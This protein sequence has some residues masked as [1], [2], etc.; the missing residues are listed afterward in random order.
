ML[1]RLRGPRDERGVVAIMVAILTCFLVIPMAALAV[2]IGVQRVTRTDAQSVADMVALDL[3]REID[4]R[5]VAELNSATPSL[6][7]LA[8]KSAQRGAVTGN[9]YNVTFELGTVTAANFDPNDPDS[10]AYFAPMTSGK[11]NSVRVTVHA[12]VGFTFIGG[13]GGA[14]RSAIG[15]GAIVKDPTDEDQ[16][17][18]VPG[19]PDCPYVSN[20]AGCMIMDSY[21]AAI[22]SGDSAVLGPL[23]RHL[24]T[25]VDA[26]VLSSSGL[27]DANVNIVKFLEILKADLNVGG[28]EEVLNANVSALQVVTAA[29]EALS[30]DAATSVAAST[31]MTQIGAHISGGTQILVSDLL[32]V[33]QGGTSALGADLNALDLAAAAVQIANGTS[34]LSLTVSGADLIG[35]NASAI[36]GS[37]PKPVCLGQGR[38]ESAQTRV[39]A[40]ATVDQAGTVAGAVVDLTNSVTGSLSSLLCSALGSLLNA[41]CYTAPVISDIQV[42][43][44]VELARAAGT[45]TDV[46]CEGDQTYLSVLKDSSLVPATVTVSV[47]FTLQ[48]KVYTTLFAPPTVTNLQSVVYATLSTDPATPQSESDK[49]YVPDDYDNPQ[50]GPSPDLSVSNL[51]VVMGTSGDPYLFD[52]VAGLANT[53]QTLLIAPL[54]NLVVKPLLTG[55]STA[56]EDL[57][58]LSLAGSTYTPLPTPNCGAPRLVG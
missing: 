12:K 54:Q 57:V 16:D 35:L 20:R 22:K 32:G 56:L 44:K 28:F 13:S 41:T 30:Q 15:I 50:A 40:N 14:N 19:D 6:Q 21:A 8:D 2:D 9:D 25:N 52:R 26:A 45:V 51:G 11:P 43:A 39:T 58:G 10:A 34:P 7:T 47:T 5:T 4:G 36:V 24:G 27:V 38:Q 55:L 17:E 42:S 1:I 37:R 53:V 29:A 46:K 33:T 31:L 48:K 49:L 23:N 18:C 3:A